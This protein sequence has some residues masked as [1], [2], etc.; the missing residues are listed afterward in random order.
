MVIYKT[1]N[2]IN[3][4]YYIGMDTKNNPEYLGSGQIFKKALLKYGRENFKKEIIQHCESF[5]ELKDAEKRIINESICKDPM[6]YNLAEGGFGGNTHLGWEE[7]RRDKFKK[8]QS[9]IN[10]GQNNPMY[11][12]KQSEE[13]RLRI[14]ESNKR[15]DHPNNNREG[16]NNPFHGKTHSNENKIKWSETRSGGGNPMAKRCI[17][18][19]QEFPST[20]DAGLALK[21]HQSTI[22]QRIN[23]PK[24]EDYYYI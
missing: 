10:S 7:S 3:G 15:E 16:S 20:R 5:N 11:G 18:E 24:R 13:G 2:L 22:R 12:I 4:K 9:E 8:L 14:S 21:I 1:T 23:N 6:S 17:A 19:G